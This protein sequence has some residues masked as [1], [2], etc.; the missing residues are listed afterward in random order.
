M[1]A[2][3]NPAGFKRE[4]LTAFPHRQRTGMLKK[5]DN[6]GEGGSLMEAA[7]GKGTIEGTRSSTSHLNV[8]VLNTLEPR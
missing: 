8:N 3:G 5:K 1:L 7:G 6:P 2:T 4:E